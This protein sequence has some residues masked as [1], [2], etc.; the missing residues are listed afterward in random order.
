MAAIAGELLSFDRFDSRGLRGANVL[1]ISSASFDPER[2]GGG[3][4]ALK[5][6]RRRALLYA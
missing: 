4:P 3:A 1:S 5:R 6:A 2:G